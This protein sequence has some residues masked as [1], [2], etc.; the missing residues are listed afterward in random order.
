[1]WEVEKVKKSFSDELETIISADFLL[2]YGVTLE[3]YWP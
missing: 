1:M 2:S 3:W